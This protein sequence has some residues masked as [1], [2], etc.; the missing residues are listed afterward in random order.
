MKITFDAYVHMLMYMPIR[1]PYKHRSL[2]VDMWHGFVHSCV[3]QMAYHL[4][5]NTVKPLKQVA[6]NPK[7]QILLVASRG[8][9]CPIHWS[10]VFSREWRCSRNSAESR[11]SNYIWVINISALFRLHLSDQQCYCLRCD[12]YYRFYDTFLRTKPHHSRWLTI[13]CAA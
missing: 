1:L 2:R 8:C 10:Q 12:L 13:F 11:C 5:S 7:I 9:L 6:P 4:V 3:C